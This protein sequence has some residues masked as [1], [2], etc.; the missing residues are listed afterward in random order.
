MWLYVAMKRVK[1]AE[2]KD[3][4][5]QH[6]RAVEAGDEVLVTDRQRPIARILPVVDP[7]PAVTIISPRGDFM[8]MRDRERPHVDLGVSSTRLLIEERGDR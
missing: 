1:I 2:L 6:L 3:H 8:A 4:L 7:R 5:S